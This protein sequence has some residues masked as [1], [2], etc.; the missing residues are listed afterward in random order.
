MKKEKGINSSCNTAVSLSSLKSFFG[1]LI[2]SSN[3]KLGR[4][5][6]Q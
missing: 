3:F 4:I 5:L 2:C 1:A 6:F